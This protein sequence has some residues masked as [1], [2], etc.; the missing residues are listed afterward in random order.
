MATREDAL[1]EL[2]RRGKL[3]ERQRSVVEELAKR[4]RIQLEPLDDSP[5]IVDYLMMGLEPAAT[6]VSGAI[7]EPVAGIAGLAKT[8]TTGAEAGAETIGQIQEAMTYQPRTE[9]GKRGMRAIGET[10]GPVI[11]PVGEAVQAVG[12]IAYRA[13]GPIAGAGVVT[14]LAAIPE[15]LGLKGSRAA[16]KMAARN[17]LQRTDP[18]D[19]F[20]EA[21]KFKP[22]IIESLKASG[23]PES[24]FLELIPERLPEQIAR[25]QR[26]TEAGV[27]PTRGELTQE[28]GQ[29]AVEQRLLQTKGDVASE[30]LRQ[31]KL[32]QSELIKDK[33]D[34]S[35]GADVTVGETGE[36]I[37]DA[38]QGRKKLLRTQKN[39]LYNLAAEKAKEVGDI[40]VFGDSITDSIPD[41]KTLRRLDRTSKGAISDLN[42]TL[43]EFGIIE[44]TDAM[45]RKGIDSEVLTIEN[46]DDL[47]QALNQI[48][49]GDQ[50]GAASVAIGPIR[51][52]LDIE[53]D[54]LAN[55]LGE[56][57]LPTDVIEPLKQ[58]RKTVTQ[59]K[60]EFDPKGLINRLI[61]KK[62]QGDDMIIEA[63][64]V[65]DKL[66]ARS[67]PVEQV[68]R[69]VNSLK[70][71]EGGDEALASMQTS[72]LMDLID[73]GFGTES[74]TISGIKTFNPIAFKKR[75]KNIG[76]DKLAKIFENN[77]KAFRNIRNIEKISSDL[78]PTAGA[79]PKGSASVILDLM[80][81]LGVAGISTKV[82]GGAFL[83]GAVDKIAQPVKTG[84]DVRRALQTEPDVIQLQNLADLHYPGIASALGIS[85][86][87]KESNE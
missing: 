28:F 19:L 16:K 4:G 1:A 2:Y 10:L 60:T 27:V 79:V 68:S 15:L 56:R 32:K 3:D 76:E 5:G 84:V 75:I 20:D 57:G 35:F 48:E 81:K 22:E 37:Q 50:S 43:A 58:A 33:L 45:V 6:M 62:G 61:T 34:S 86:A 87:L 71:A 36:L 25:Q 24:E 29:Q 73:A 30:P 47:R 55:T 72:V 74:R 44:P 53:V 14:A 39:D 70:K 49:R 41:E 80:N 7:A 26:F 63:S 13:G 54:E 66:S 11:E 18:T 17:I 12:D 85:T 42:E 9:A 46:F 77:K 38:L 8:I 82:P 78:V 52:A 69:T 59:L 83:L 67:T 21:G 64:K 23:I 51:K 65:Y 40:P 31:F